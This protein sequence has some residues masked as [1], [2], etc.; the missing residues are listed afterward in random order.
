MCGHLNSKV[1]FVTKMS[2]EEN[3]E[4]WSKG[5]V[6][7]KSTKKKQTKQNI[8]THKR[9]KQKVSQTFE[10]ISFSCWIKERGNLG[11]QEIDYFIAAQG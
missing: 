1:C 8:Y 10:L 5:S 4:T 9:I 2:L 6:L 3:F 11:S 7:E